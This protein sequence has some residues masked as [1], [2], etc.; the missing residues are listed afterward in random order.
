MTNAE[1]TPEFF[2]QLAEVEV[3][4]DAVAL[5]HS[6]DAISDSQ[7]DELTGFA[8]MPAAYKEQLV[9]V[10]FLILACSLKQGHRGTY[11]VELILITTNNMRAIIRDS[12]KGILE[13]VKDIM[14][15]PDLNEYMPLKMGMWVRKGLR[16]EDYPFTE[17]TTNKTI[18]SRT[19]YLDM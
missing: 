14:W 13:Q 8:L 17:P 12:S 19:Y 2:K 1:F 18:M 7:A 10:P 4:H 15:I 16:Y 5:M 6:Y 9:G 3:F 11:F